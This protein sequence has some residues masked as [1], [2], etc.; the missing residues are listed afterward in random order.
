MFCFPP[1]FFFFFFVE[2]GG[3]IY[4]G[5]KS[6]LSKTQLKLAFYTVKRGQMERQK[7]GAKRERERK[8]EQHNLCSDGDYVPQKQMIKAG[9]K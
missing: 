1:L 8:V 5:M 2:G 3:V 4:H 6:Q 7:Q 9:R